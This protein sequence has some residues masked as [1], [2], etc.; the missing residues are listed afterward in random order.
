MFEEHRRLEGLKH[1]EESGCG[2]ENDTR[3]DGRGRKSCVSRSMPIIVVGCS[4][5]FIVCGLHFER[6]SC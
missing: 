6:L 1:A 5:Q 3:G 4:L 2:A